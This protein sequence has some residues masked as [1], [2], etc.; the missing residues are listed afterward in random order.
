MKRLNDHHFH[1]CVAHKNGSKHCKHD[2]SIRNWCCLASIRSCCCLTS[3]R[4]MSCNHYNW[5]M[6]SMRFPDTELQSAKKLRKYYFVLQS[7]HKVRPGT[8]SYY[9]ACT[10]YFPV[11]LRT[12]KLEQST[13]QYYFI[14]QSLL[15]VLPSTI[16]YYKAC[17]KYLPVLLRT[18]SVHNGSTNCCDFAAPKPDLD[19][20]GE[21][22][23]F[24]SIF[25]KEEIP[26]QNHQCQNEKIAAKARSQL[27]RSHYNAIHD[28]QMQNTVILWRS[29]SN[30]MC[31]HWDAK[32]H[33]IMHNSSTN[34]N[35]FAAPKPDLRPKAETRSF[36]SAFQ[37]EFQKENHQCQ[38]LKNQLPKHRSQLSCSH[39]NAIHDSQMQ[40][41]KVLR[42]NLDAAI[43]RQSAD[44]ELRNAIELRTTAPQIAAILQLQNRMDL[45]AK[46]EKTSILTRVLKGFFKGKSSKLK[47]QLPKH[48]SQLACS[49]YKCNSRLS[50]ANTK[51]WRLQLQMRG[52]LTQPFHCDLQTL[53]CKTQK[54]SIIKEEKKSPGTISSTAR[55]VRARF[56]GKA[57]TPAPVAHA[58][59]LF[60]ATEP[61][62]TRKNTMFRANPNIQIAPM[63]RENEAFVRGFLQIPRVEAVKTNLSCEA[64]LKFQKFKKWAHLFSAAVLLQ[65]VC[66]HM[67]NTK[68]QHHQRR[69]KITWNHQFHCARSSSKISRQSDDTRTRRGREPTF[70]RNGTSVYPK[71]C[72]VSCQSEQ[73]N[74]TH[75]SW[76][77]SFRARL[78]SNS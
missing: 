1:L 55:A 29:H 68:A 77:R 62:F 26:K 33:R 70:L 24:W 65:K 74:R 43:P 44:T 2:A 12:A 11:L 22:R 45:D 19:A 54:H 30:S 57:T 76:K 40:N 23:R 25:E 48:R 47:N 56:H 50:D 61:P 17:T 27:S 7:L 41:T 75:D 67:Q 69:E 66:Q 39:Y 4:N 59:Q 20:K 13:S 10:K 9:K 58:S 52:T 46:A 6:L 15:K 3:V 31:K 37:K 14:V 34:C 32:R 8:T 42:S 5:M 35:D 73:S 36:W 28:S 53:S 38:N 72:N 64:S 16:S 63:I 60:S 71:K 18:R 78:P 21:K 51:V 49:H